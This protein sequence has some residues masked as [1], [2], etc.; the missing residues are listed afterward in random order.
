M[1][2]VEIDAYADVV[3]PWCFIAHR[4]LAAIVREREDVIVRHRP[5]ILQAG[6][7]PEGEDLHA[8]LRARYGAE[9]ATVFARV[10]EAAHDAGIPLDLTKQ[11]MTYDTVAAH[12]L[13][14][15]AAAKETQHELLDALFSAYF[16]EARNIADADVLAEIAAPYGFPAAEVRRLLSDPAELA[17]TETESRAAAQRGIRGV[18]LFI[19]NDRLV[20]AGAQREATFRETIAKAQEE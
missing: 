13:L 14:R 18:P 8:M 4:R 1:S 5:Y 10:E 7:P 3:C 12:T 16:L 19:L 20:L 15:H 6:A 11:P 2:A 9:P 17:A